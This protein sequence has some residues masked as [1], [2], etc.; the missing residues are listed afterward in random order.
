VRC[1]ELAPELALGLVTGPERAEALLHLQGCAACRD[2]LAELARLH[3]SLLAL[4]PGAE[5]PAGFEARVLDR[6]N[7]RQVR[8]ARRRLAL[9]T[10]GVLA[11]AVVGGVVVAGVSGRGPEPGPPAPPPSPASPDAG[12]RTVMYAPLTAGDHEI[13]QVYAYR[14]SPSWIYVYLE[15]DASPGPLTCVLQREDGTT[16]ATASFQVTGGDAFWGGPV[17]LDRSGLARI[18]VSDATG[19]VL[20]TARF[21]AVH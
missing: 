1:R 4:I 2:H 8:P 5:P 19:T 6:L 18:R 3:D 14:G 7:T 9:A 20:A 12:E 17:P 15:A 13:G 10:A 11:A 21:D 16:M